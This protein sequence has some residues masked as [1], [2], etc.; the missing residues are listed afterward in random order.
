MGQR[1][2]RFLSTDRG[3]IA[4]ML[5]GILLAAIVSA[6]ISRNVA[7]NLRRS[8]AQAAASSWT[9]S[10]LERI[11]DF[12]ALFGGD[13]PSARILDVLDEAS[14]GGDI[15]RYRIWSRSG[16]L[17][18]GGERLRSA[19]TAGSLSSRCGEEMA[20]TI[21]SG[22]PWTTLQTGK[23]PE[24][25][26][27]Y[28]VSFIPIQQ[29]GVVIGVVET[30]QDQS[31]E[32]GLYR[33]SALFSEGF[34][35]LAILLAGGVP[36]VWGIGKMRKHRAA[37]AR[38]R[39][40]VEHDSLTGLATRQQLSEAGKRALA[41]SGRTN[42][43]VAMLLV[44]L[45]NFKD[46]NRIYGHLA[47]DEV[48]RQLACRLNSSIRKEDVAARGGGDEF[49]VLQVGMAQPSGATS[50]AN[51]IFTILREPYVVDEVK[52]TCAASL[53]VAISPADASEWEPL[54]SAADAALRKAKAGGGNA[55]CFYE[56]GMD[57]QL[58]EH[59]QIE[60]DLRRALGE[61]AFQLAYQP[62]FN[63]ADLSLLGFEALLRWP[64]G[65]PP[66][67]PAEFIPVAEECG[68]MPALGAWVL[69]NACR[70][71]AGWS[72]PVTIAVNLSPVQFR[73]GDIVET[74]ENALQATGL[75]PGRLELEV[76]ES[77]WIQNQDAVLDQ[78]ERLRRMGVSIA[79]DD[80]GT[81][82]SSLAYLWK[83]P[84]D[85]VK[86]DRNF[87]MEMEADAKAA[88]IVKTI[89]ALGKALHLS[90]TAEGVETES[91]AQALR[92]L[93]CDQAQGFLYGRPL[94]AEA[95]NEL[96][97]AQDVDA[98]KTGEPE[99]AVGFVAASSS[100]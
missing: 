7:A 23:M 22:T 66:R 17:V 97:D 48:L 55:L 74:V 21:L 61:Q 56:A 54:L 86:I 30:Y 33:R 100:N 75:T 25:P 70:S 52:V 10:L 6:A 77:L 64:A 85:R 34:L 35:G 44:N 95:A 39:F 19:S 57:E 71:A 8:D 41:W 60:L 68:L 62:V 45:D 73:G 11:G 36:G 14:R 90:I 46:V 84:F 49:A 82:Y 24:D 29:E 20:R 12:R 58:R 81:G 91:Q 99:D 87:V 79:L 51:R 40:L 2:S 96:V 37:Q 1:S 69:E 38:A 83:F 28:A 59:R 5:L 93:G 80:F 43:H 94:A 3:L 63:F 47:A 15:Y 78:L 13:P 67:S 50:L 42:Q 98:G 88:V 53:G 31:S 65:W 89:V 76:T 9:D 72:H 26:A 32:Q 27:N 18:Y 16:S 92:S 4:L